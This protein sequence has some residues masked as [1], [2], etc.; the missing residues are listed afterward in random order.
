M[1]TVTD[2]VEKKE[3]EVSSPQI[4]PNK[5][6]TDNVNS[7]I[8][9]NDES[10][11]KAVNSINDA[12][13]TYAEGLK[14]SNEQQ[15]S[16]TKEYNTK[17]SENDESFRNMVNGWIK[18]AEEEKEAQ[19]KQNEAQ[20]K[21]DYQ[22][23][24]FGGIA[25]ASAAIANLIGTAHGASPQKWQSPQEKWAQRADQYRRERD[26]KLEKLDAQLK[27]LDR[28][29]AQLNY[30]MGKEQSERD[31]KAKQSEIN[32]ANEV[33]KTVYGGKVK[34]ASV[35]KEG[36]LKN[37]ELAM[38]GLTMNGTASNRSATESYR[39]YQQKLHGYDPETGLFYN[40]STGQYDSI[41]PVTKSTQNPP[42]DDKSKGKDTN[43]G[44]DADQTQPK[45]EETSNKIED[46]FKNE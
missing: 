45:T 9:S 31:Y 41:I 40:P 35:K 34:A 26:A 6:I 20:N 22:T 5:G 38:R 28:Q 18:S 14:A 23:R 16:A 12:T 3:Q 2:E 24:L 33:A 15:Q 11:T 4:D 32:G 39:S 13:N 29:K 42:K 37:I 30:T 43:K 36:D 27:S 21:S 1:A 8:R 19:R 44:K 25:E 7:F 46:F 17:Q 10:T